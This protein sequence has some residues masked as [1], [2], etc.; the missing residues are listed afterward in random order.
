MSDKINSNYLETYSQIFSER[1]CSD[2]FGTKK[3]INGQEIIQLTPSDQVNLMVIKTLFAAWQDELGK[4]KSNPYFDYKDYAVEEVLKEFMNVLSRAIKI[5]RP[6]FEPLLK[7]AVQD[8]V[9]L[10]VDP[11]MFYSGEIER[12]DPESISK[13]LKENKRYLKWHGQLMAV[14]IEKS[15]LG[16]SEGQLKRSLSANY[17]YLKNQLDQPTDLLERLNQ[18][19]AID[20]E[21][22]LIGVGEVE[23]SDQTEPL[24]VA[25]VAEP[26]KPDAKEAQ[27]HPQHQPATPSKAIDPALAW[28]KFEMEEYSYM[29]GSLSSLSESVN[30]NQKIMFTKVLFGGNH[31][32]MMHAFK[33]IDGSESFVDAIEL[34]NQRYVGELD[35]EIDSDEVGE[36]L[37]LVF[38]KFDQ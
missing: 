27:F 32:L 28:A 22:L 36:F 2:Y 5:E 26:Q 29:K 7:K 21:L 10:A 9:L 20:Y 35:W 38:R 4:L 30:I 6:A 1:I 16:V 33:G 13:Y 15:D 19:E 23:E 31:D 12:A 8:T 17:D 25:P 3:F 14:L 37:Q 11:V 18:V 24:E 34:L